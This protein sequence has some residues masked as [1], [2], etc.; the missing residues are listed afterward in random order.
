M[1]DGVTDGQQGYVGGQKGTTVSL[2]VSV[3][4]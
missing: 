3:F 4:F 2:A 1:A